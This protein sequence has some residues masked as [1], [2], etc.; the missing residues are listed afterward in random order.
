MSISS[1]RK[2]AIVNNLIIA[3]RKS[4]SALEDFERVYKDGA[5]EILI[6]NSILIKRFIQ[7]SNPSLYNEVVEDFST[8]TLTV[9]L[10]M[11]IKSKVPDA[12]DFLNL[13]T[14]FY[15]NELSKLS[16][17]SGWATD[18]FHNLF[19]EN[20]F[21]TKI[22]STNNS[23]KCHL[24]NIALDNMIELLDQSVETIIINY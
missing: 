6:F 19:Y 2:E 21:A 1:A 24:F 5:M 12:I 10:H 14:D 7:Y 18:K 20:P 23:E 15:L 9:L 17:E 8:M 3:A 16:S 13:R 4:M 22:I 11:G